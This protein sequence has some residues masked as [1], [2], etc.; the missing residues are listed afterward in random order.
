MDDQKSQADKAFDRV[1]RAAKLLDEAWQNR[2]DSPTEASH[3]LGE[4]NAA[5]ESLVQAWHLGEVKP[6]SV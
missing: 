3:A 6:S 1:M 2:E 4:L 5:G